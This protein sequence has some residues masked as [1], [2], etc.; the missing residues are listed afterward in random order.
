MTLLNETSTLSGT[1][2][3]GTADLIDEF[4]AEE[5]D[6]YRLDVTRIKVLV[7]ECCECG[8]IWEETE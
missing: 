4:I 2:K 5:D 3:H 1:C 6:P 8:K 7:F